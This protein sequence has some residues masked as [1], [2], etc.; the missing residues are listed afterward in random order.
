MAVKQG[1]EEFN[2]D[3]PHPDIAGIKSLFKFSNFDE[4]KIRYLNDL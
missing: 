3:H 1:L 2:K 4:N